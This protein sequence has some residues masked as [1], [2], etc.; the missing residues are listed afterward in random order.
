V[1]DPLWHDGRVTGGTFEQRI[2]GTGGVVDLHAALGSES[3]PS[4]LALKALP[5]A[6]Q[7]KV[8]AFLD[9]LGRAEFD[10][11]GDDVRD[12]IDL[13]AFLQAK[14]GGPYTADSP[15]AVFDFD[16]DGDVDNADQ[17]AFRLVYEDDCNGN[18]INDL[19]DVLGGGAPDANHNLIP[20][21]CETCQPDIGLM[22]P[23]TAKLSVCGGDLS[24]GNQATLSIVGTP[25]SAP[26]LFLATFVNLG[27]PFMGGVLVDTAPPLVLGWV[28]DANGNVQFED[29]PPSGLG[30]FVLYFQAVYVDGSLPMGYGIT[31]ALQVQLLP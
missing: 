18:G 29:L 3:R 1:R 20:D 16:Q 31:N 28:A 17:N 30:N 24:L 14:G 26:T 7:L 19:E 11:N 22:G 9:S 13:A 21:A 6:D 4:A 8:L 12:Q 23:G 25:P 2:L 27:Q 10:S 15:E 5:F